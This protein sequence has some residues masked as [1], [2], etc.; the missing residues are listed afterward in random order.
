MKT[1]NATALDVANWFLA[2]AGRDEEQPDISNLKLQKLLYFA[3]GHHLAKTGEPLFPDE[4]QAWAHG[5]VVPNVYQAF[6]HFEGN[7]ITSEVDVN[8]ESFSKA[9]NNLLASIWFTFGGFS[10]WKLR[11]MT[12]QNGPWKECHESTSFG[13]VIPTAVMRDYFT[14]LYSNRG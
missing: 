7:A 5:P 1:A 3:Q 12:H 6:K 14:S 4:I 8:F 11:E 10:A 2:W 9:T 13:A